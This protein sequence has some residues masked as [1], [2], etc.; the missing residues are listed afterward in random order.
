V[1]SYGFVQNVDGLR[2]YRKLDGKN[3]LFLVLYVNYILL[4][5]NDVEI[6]S[7]IKVSLSCQFIMKDTI[8]ANYI[9]G[10]KLLRDRKQR[11]LGLSQTS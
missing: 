1:K 3:V 6:L 5:G 10:T 9:C 7:S 11:M 2:V 4:I 8:E